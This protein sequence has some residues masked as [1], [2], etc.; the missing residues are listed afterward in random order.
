MALVAS[1]LA[2]LFFQMSLTSLQ[3]LNCWCPPLRLNRTAVQRKFSSV[4]AHEDYGS[5]GPWTAWRVTQSAKQHLTTLCMAN[6]RNIQIKS[7]CFTLWDAALDNCSQICLSSVL[8]CLEHVQLTALIQA[9]SSKHHITH[10]AFVSLI[11][12]A[13]RS[14]TLC[15]CSGCKTKIMA[16]RNYNNKEEQSSESP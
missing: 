4:S 10:I 5:S 6:I 12:V 2:F 8:T 11:P 9:N 14:P 15:P 13:V 16:N 3:A 1:L 7:K